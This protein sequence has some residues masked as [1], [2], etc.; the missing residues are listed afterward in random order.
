[1]TEPKQLARGIGFHLYEA[2]DVFSK[3]PP[4]EF[5]QHRKPK[6]E[7][8]TKFLSDSKSWQ[9]RHRHPDVMVRA[10]RESAGLPE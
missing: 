1:M 2:I 4:R 7:T 5:D 9:L 10:N 8:G 6:A 3:S